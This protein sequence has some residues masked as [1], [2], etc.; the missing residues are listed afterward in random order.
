M[1]YIDDDFRVPYK[2][3]FDKA[4]MNA[5]YEHGFEVGRRGHEWHSTPPGYK[6]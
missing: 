6:E 5:L 2:G 3:P 1:A 4:Y